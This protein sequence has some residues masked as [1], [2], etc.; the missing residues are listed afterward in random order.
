MTTTAGR[1]DELS[2]IV[3]QLFPQLSPE[4]QEISIQIYRL[5]AEGQPVATSDIAAALHIPE[6][7][8]T[9]I[10][11]DWFG[12]FY[13]DD[14]RIIGFWGLALAEMPHRFEVDGQQLYTWCAWDTLFIPELI[15][16]TATVVSVCPVTRDPVTLT[17]T[18]E[19]IRDLNPPEVVMSFVA[20]DEEQFQQ[21]IVMSFCHY[22]HFF[23]SRHAGE[24]WVSSHPNTFLIS[25][26]E[27]FELGHRKNEYQFPDV[28]G[29]RSELL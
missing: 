11:D 8:I 4:R 24:Q 15:Q 26:E 9:A 19:G 16:K 5:L 3:H 2:A 6:Q 1:M 20:P 12:F 29:S 27:A 23:S 28:P 22:V 17:V 25:M 21:N 18:P 13:D 14:K 10:L 7:K